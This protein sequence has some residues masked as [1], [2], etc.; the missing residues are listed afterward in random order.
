MFR[1]GII[2]LAATLCA[3]PQSAAELRFAVHADPKTFDPL[4]AE[5]EV[6]ETI[7]YLTGGVLI[8]FNRNTQRPEP[9]LA[10]SWKVLDHAQ[11][12]D[13]VL[14]S[15][16]TF[17]DGTPFGPEDVVATLRRMMSPELHAGIADAFRSAGGQITARANGPNAVSVTF[18]TSV[19]GLEL[20]FDQLAISPARHVPPESAVLGPFVVAEHKGGQY[21]MLRRNPH[22]WK[23]DASGQRLPLL[24]SIRL[25][26]QA[27]RETE[28]LRFRR[29]EL[30]LV[31]KVEPEAF[32]RLSKDMPASAL[33]AGPSLDTEFF[34]FNLRPDAPGP[35]YK[36]RWFQ[37]K[38]FRQAMSVA[39][40]RDDMIRLVYRGY[41]Q[42]AAGPVSPANKYWFNSRLSPEK[43]DP[44][45]ALKLLRA[46]G[47]RLEGSTLRDREGNAVEF[48]LITNAGSTTRT[49]IGTMLQQDLAK[50]GIRINFLPIEFQSL[51]ER[52]SRSQQ[53]EACLLGF[54]NVE[55]DPNSQ[56]NIWMSSGNLHAW[57][58]AQAHPA[59]PWEAEIDRLM[60]EQHASIEEDA[61][62]KA[63]DR[64][65]ELVSEQRPIIYLVHPDVLLAIS[66]SVQHAEPTPLPPHLYWNIENLALAAAG[67]RRTN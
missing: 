3:R 5:E 48:S 8:R 19:A 22:Y 17:S 67:Q 28:L 26:I 39:L 46:D 30:H 59:T 32:A 66:P 4:L 50:I 43:Y 47:F 29:G 18:S 63:F 36:K 9:E 34:W 21:V 12:I 44:Q 7:R 37:S 27:N 62:K 42:A 15:N 35:A 6:S 60:Q 58:P 31:D 40:N 25:D 23:T 16:V 13:F 11:R 51:V 1:V 24:D 52:I 64:L 65:Q 55:I 33:N 54:T 56:M 53:Y 14:R 45:R 10:V 61:R 38:L 57:S 20:L 2:L 49:E 41:A